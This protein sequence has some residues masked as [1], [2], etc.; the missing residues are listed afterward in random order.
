MKAS[1]PQGWLQA[2]LNTRHLGQKK[3]KQNVVFL[4][5]LIASAPKGTQGITFGVYLLQTG[6]LGPLA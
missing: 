6:L 1:P 2:L 3:T 4:C 5:E